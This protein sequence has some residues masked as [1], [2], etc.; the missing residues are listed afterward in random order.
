MFFQIELN[1][2]TLSCDGGQ[3]GVYTKKK[4]THTGFSEGHKRNNPFYNNSI[5]HGF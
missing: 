1:V 2:E 5:T 4:T 3:L